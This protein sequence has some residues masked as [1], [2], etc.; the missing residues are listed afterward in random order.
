MLPIITNRAICDL[1]IVRD[2]TAEAITTVSASSVVSLNNPVANRV[3]LAEEK[4]INTS[5]NKISKYGITSLLYLV[6]LNQ[7]T[8]QKGEERRRKMQALLMLNL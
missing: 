4:F 3:G 7:K 6:L 8:K 2:L 5:A 1:K